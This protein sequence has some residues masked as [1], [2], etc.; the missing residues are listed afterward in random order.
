LAEKLYK[1]HHWDVH[2]FALEH[3]YYGE[4]FPVAEDTSREEEEDGGDDIPDYNDLTY[5]SSRQ[6]VRDIIQFVQSPEVSNHLDG[7]S[8]TNIQWI[9]FGGSYPGMLSA[10]SRL[11]Y[12]DIIYGAVSNSAPV[13][14]Q[15]DFRQYHNHVA[16]DLAD[17][18]VGGSDE[19]HRIVVEGHEQ[20]VNALEGKSF[21]DE[22]YAGEDRM[23]YIADLFNVCDGA[24]TLKA[25]RRNIEVLI[26]DGII[27]VPSQEN[28]PSCEQEFCNIQKVS[29]FYFFGSVCLL[30]SCI[31]FNLHF[32]LSIKNSY[33]MQSSAKARSEKVRPTPASHLCKSWPK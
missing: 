15:L 23:E 14:A 12:P 31:S 26:G 1:E 32:D 17:K 20:I 25:N 33:V 7:E 4:S 8:S 2:L 28:D 30:G 22:Q 29:L 6:A 16:W 19:C 9:T 18:A 5:L 10:W 27:S 13:Q 3:R 11:L 21:P 24:D